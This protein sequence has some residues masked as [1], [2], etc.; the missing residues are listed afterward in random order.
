VREY[1]GS[2]VSLDN[3]FGGADLVRVAVRFF[4]ALHNLLGV[5]AYDRRL[6]R[7]LNAAAGELAEVVGL[8]VYDAEQHDL[9]RR[10]NHESLYFSRLAGDRS[11]ELLTLQNSSMHAGA[12]GR[13]GEALQLVSPPAW[14]N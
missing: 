5:G 2:L 8:L 11:I 14:H 4:G 7:D 6:E 1:I 12:M 10:M 13:P 9:V 3:R